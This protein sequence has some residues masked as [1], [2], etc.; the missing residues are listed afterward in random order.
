MA[1]YAHIQSLRIG[2]KDVAVRASEFSLSE[3]RPE[4]GEG[5]TTGTISFDVVGRHLD[6]EQ[7]RGL[8]EMIGAPGRRIAL[9]QELRA[10]ECELFAATLRYWTFL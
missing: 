3:E 6:D 1:Q 4:K 2:G 9:A 7:W 10:A 8:L 5:S